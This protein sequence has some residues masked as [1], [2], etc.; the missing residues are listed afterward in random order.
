MAE[1]FSD[2]ADATDED[3]V[4]ATMGGNMSAYDEIVRRY[5]QTI[6]AS[7]YHFCKHQGDLEDLVQETFIRT[8]HKLGKWTP[9][10]PLVS[11]I[12]RIGYNLSYDYLRKQKRNPLA[13]RQEQHD[14]ESDDH[15]P[16]LQIA[17]ESHTADVKS[18]RNDLMDWLLEQLKAEEA[19]LVTLMYVEQMAVVDIADRLGWGESKVKVRI[20]RTRK[21]LKKLLESNEELKLQYSTTL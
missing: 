3:L 19:M 20:H 5:Q 12:R 14:A 11:W 10:A 16:E 18:S 7:L 13:I 17:D 6:A 15:R 21:K 4:K 8:F 1:K 9:K 2:L